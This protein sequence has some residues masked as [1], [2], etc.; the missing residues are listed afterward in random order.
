MRFIA[1]LLT[2]IFI[3]S[4][5]LFLITTNI[6]L[7]TN[8]IRLY[9]Y[10][11]EK[12]EVSA[13]TGIDGNELTQAAKGLI[14]YFNSSQE[15]IQISVLIGV[16]EAE[17]FNEREVEHLADVKGLIRL[18]Y[19]LQEGVTLY[20]LLFALVGSI[21]GGRR[22]LHRLSRGLLWGG[23]LTVV[24]LILLGIGALVGFDQLFLWF[25]HIFFSTDTW[26]LNPAT[27]RLIMMFPEGFFY[28]ATLFIAGT[29]AIE[30]LLIGGISGGL[31]LRKR[32]RVLF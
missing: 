11:F 24:L 28:D 30:A 15:P 10:G 19:Y 31:L 23:I 26:Q 7:A 5:P 6:R 20:I 12:Y 18:D 1:N 4:I 27:D 17:L 22:F 29:T 2:L 16:E 8:E 25:H 14:E 9:Q 13:V 3:I 21:W 32:R